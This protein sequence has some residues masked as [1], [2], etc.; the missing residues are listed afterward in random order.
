M[1]MLIDAI[2]TSFGVIGLLPRGTFETSKDDFF[3][4]LVKTFAL[5]G[6]DMRDLPCGNKHT[7]MSEESMEY[8]LAHISQVMQPY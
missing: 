2:D 8:R 4:L 1:A 6:Q 3:L 5:S 7:C